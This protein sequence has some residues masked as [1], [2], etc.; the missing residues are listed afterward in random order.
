MNP[1]NNTEVQL[2]LKQLKI[3]P[4]K[5]LGQNFLT[6]TNIVKKIISISDLSQNDTILEIGP[7]LGAITVE[8]VKLAKKIYA[9]EIDRRLCS[10]LEDKFSIYDNIEIIQGDI[11]KI[12]IPN[13][14]K[15]VSNIPY[16]MTGPILDRIFFRMNSPIG[17]LIIEKS[18][19]DRIFISGDYKRFSRITISVN[20]FMEP[21]SQTKISRKSFY[22]VPKVALSLIKLI[23]KYPIDSFFSER[24]ALEFFLRFISGIM[25]YKNKNIVNAIDLFFKKQK[26]IHYTKE[27]V[28]SILQ[29]NNYDNKKVFDFEID[30]YTKISKLFYS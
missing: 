6:D 5:F 2:L 16:K 12:Q 30:E 17:I 3:P 22:P 23:P 27:E 14:N 7:G 4:N 8:L 21:T 26:D 28:N 18:I 29:M 19:S 10:Y 20:T 25:P 24:R 1:M 13:H 9:I 11:L 15:V